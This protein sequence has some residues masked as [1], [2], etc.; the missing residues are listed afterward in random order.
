M[1]TELSIKFSKFKFISNFENNELL[2]F[3]HLIFWFIAINNIKS[4]MKK[5][6][7]FVVY[8]H[9][10]TSEFLYQKEWVWK[11]NLYYWWSMKWYLQKKILKYLNYLYMVRENLI[12][13]FLSLD[14][15]FWKYKTEYHKLLLKHYCN[16]FVFYS[17]HK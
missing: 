12:V 13:S 17:H 14:E 5:E 4:A 9:S 3:F 8:I 16:L 7:Y 1:L 15:K 2:Y 10:V 6:F 11:C